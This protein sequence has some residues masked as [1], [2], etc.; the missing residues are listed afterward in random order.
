MQIISCRY[1]LKFALL[2]CMNYSLVILNEGGN[3]MSNF[4]IATGKG[5]VD[6]IS[7]SY[8]RILSM[9]LALTEA[10][11]LNTICFAPDSLHD[12]YIEWTWLETTADYAFLNRGM[13][14]LNQREAELRCTFDIKLAEFI[15]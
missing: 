4:E 13:V 6:I 5:S 14:Y 7:T 15:K 8:D 10:P 1:K 2:G 3:D 9:P 12:T 11:A